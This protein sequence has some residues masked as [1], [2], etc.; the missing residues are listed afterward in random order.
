MFFGSA[1]RVETILR[2]EMFRN[3]KDLSREYYQVN[4][5]DNLMSLFTNDLDTV[6][7]CFGWGI[8]MFLDALFLGALAVAKM[9]QMDARLTLLTMIP[10]GTSCWLPARWWEAT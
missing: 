8:M 4:K 10:M 1:I 5:V 6:Q 7:E 2:N 9:W 3:A